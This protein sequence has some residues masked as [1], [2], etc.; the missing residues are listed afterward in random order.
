MNN[1]VK[2]INNIGT[3]IAEIWNIIKCFCIETKFILSKKAMINKRAEK[4]D[5]DAHMLQPFTAT[6]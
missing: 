5:N 4:R 2:K 1:C 6:I 3:P